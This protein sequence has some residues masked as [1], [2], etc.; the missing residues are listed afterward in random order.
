MKLLVLTF[1]T[2]LTNPGLHH[3]IN[4]LKKFGY[5]YVILEG[6]QFSWGGNNY[7]HIAEWLK[8]NRK[9]Y[10][11][12]LYTDAWDTIAMCD[13]KNIIDYLRYTKN[14][15]SWLTSAEKNGCFAGDTSLY[16]REAIWKY[17]CAGNYLTSIDLFISIVE[18]EPRKEGENDQHWQS[19]LFLSKK[20]NWKLDTDC[21]IFQTLYMEEPSDFAWTRNGR[22]L[23]CY[24]ATFPNFIHGN[25]KCDMRWI[26][27]PQSSP[28]I[29]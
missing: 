3:L 5:D 15:E 11:H 19:R 18:S 21:R 24:T 29:K 17:P 12:F 16:D 25:G 6:E 28:F 26:Y 7:V 2:N 14:R 27:H 8:K 1:S 9:D 10:T 20:Y 4:S 22:L 23:N 13:S